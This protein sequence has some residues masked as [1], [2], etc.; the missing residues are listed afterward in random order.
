M[1]WKIESNCVWI[2]NNKNYI[3]TPCI[4]NKIKLK[5]TY[6]KRNHLLHDNNEMILIY[7]H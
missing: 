7:K 4:L 3:Q 2:I 6:I 5:K 1:E